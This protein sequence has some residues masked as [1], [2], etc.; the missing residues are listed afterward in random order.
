M[1]NVAVAV[2]YILTVCAGIL[3]WTKI[4]EKKEK[5][6]EIEKNSKKEKTSIKEETGYV[7]D[8]DYLFE[9]DPWLDKLN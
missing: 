3:I 6:K 2:G 8:Y 5:S 4:E 7:S 1:G 9:N